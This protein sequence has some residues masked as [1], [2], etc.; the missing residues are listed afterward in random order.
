MSAATVAAESWR[1]WHPGRRAR[2]G[3][4]ASG[5]RC[6]HRAAPRCTRVLAGA[7]A[8][9]PAVAVLSTLARR[10]S[11]PMQ[12]AV[13]ATAVDLHRTIGNTAVDRRRTVSCAWSS[14]EPLA[15]IVLVGGVLV[16]A[17]WLM[18]G[19]WVLGRIRREADVLDPVPEPITRAQDRVGVAAACIVS[20]GSPDRSRSGS[21]V[22]SSCFRR[23]CGDLRSV[24]PARHRVPRTAARPPPRLGLPDGRRGHSHRCSGSILPCGG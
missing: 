17:V 18:I 24:D 20:A 9:L 14:L 5:S 15:A 11:P 1:V 8:G 4:R 13:V 19:A 23:E 21:A 6:S 2:L 7:P 3:R 12:P 22:R 16:R 10:A